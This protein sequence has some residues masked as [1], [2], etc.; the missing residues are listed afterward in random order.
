MYPTSFVA[1]AAIAFAV[2]TSCLPTLLSGPDFPDISQPLA[3]PKGL[4]K[5]GRRRC[6]HSLSFHISLT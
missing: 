4:E 5:K 2:T 1:A 6:Q 3:D